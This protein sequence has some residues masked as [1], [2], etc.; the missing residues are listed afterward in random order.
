LSCLVNFQSDEYK[1]LGFD[2]GDE[3]EAS[4]TGRGRW[5]LLLLLLLLLS[6]VVAVVFSSERRDL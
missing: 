4:Y 3:E 2:V 6:F 5:L 1:R